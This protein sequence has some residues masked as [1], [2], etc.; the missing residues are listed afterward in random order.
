MKCWRLVY[1]IFPFV[2]LGVATLQSGPNHPAR[3][4][5]IATVAQAATDDEIE[6]PA[7]VQQD[8]NTDQAAKSNEAAKPA[9][10]EKEKPKTWMD[11]IDV[12]FGDNVVDPL[13]AVL[14]YDL[15][16]IYSYL[17]SLFGVDSTLQ[18]K[19][20]FVVLWLLCGA[21]YF[22]LRMKFINLRA[23]GHAIRLTKG[24]YD[25]KSEPGEVSH[26]QAL[27]SALSAT[28]GLGNIAGV[29]IAIGQ[30]GPGA[31][32]WLIVAG[33]LGMSSKFAECT[34]G[35]MY[36][37]V[38]AGG[39]VSGGAMHYLKDGLAEMKLAGLGKVLAVMFAILCVGGSFGGGNAFQVNQSLRALG[40]KIPLLDHENPDGMPWIYGLVMAT[41]AGVVI[42]GGIRRIA[43]TAEKIVPIMCGIYVATCFIIIAGHYNQIGWAVGE[44][45]R[46]AFTPDAAYGGALGV[47]VIGIKRA[48]F[49]NEAGV[50]SAAIAHSAAKTKEPVSE[51]IVALLEPF[52]D[53][54]V[55]CTLSALVIIITGVYDAERF[56]E[57]VVLVE[58]NNGAALTMKAF[59]DVISWF[60]WVLCAT[61]FLFAYSTL[62]SWSYYGERCWTWLFGPR[63]S[64]SYKI[65]F[66]IATF[67]GSVIT[68]TKV[69]DFSD[70]MIL[71][72]AVPNVLGVVL[73]S[74][75][76]RH[77]LDDYWRRVQSGEIAPT[78]VS[79]AF[80]KAKD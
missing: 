59:G 56:P 45:F 50:G 39:S 57:Y 32:F 65:L 41:M 18:A 16:N 38:D 78:D 6:T 2:L 60:P 22:T 44:I 74:G 69:L 14:F 54:V 19:V 72:M 73:L 20:P 53:T 42:I 62:I 40:Q 79:K 67:L 51:G 25:D 30:G 31:V 23:F 24:D 11:R 8:A 26:F 43:A 36:R 28:V 33:F 68:A 64:L 58:R 7:I 21:I 75:K 52:I 46:G 80:R 29:A 13:D 17:A 76:V 37:K 1:L 48:A 15:G 71:A 12:W 47:M 66:L 61:V 49:S 10:A 5:Q 34:L 9:A 70:L 55:V 77:A 63:S 27:A 4:E 35:Q 3:A